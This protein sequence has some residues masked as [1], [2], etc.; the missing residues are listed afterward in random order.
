MS[1]LL[2]MTTEIV[3]AHASATGMKKEDLL[4]EIGQVFVRLAGIAGVDVPAGQVPV[5]Q[6]APAEPEPIK[7]AVPLEAAFGAD[8]VFCMECGQ[9]MKT[10]KRHISSA[11]GMKPG[12]YRR[13]FG[14]PSG[15]PLVAKNYSDQRKAMA[16]DLKLGERLV[17]AR[18][19]KGKK[20]KRK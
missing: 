17:K 3:S 2:A 12:E 4:E 18:A 9:G 10:L 19:A 8:K 6:A 20:A 5:P 7:P 1:K 15:T 14:I 16:K 13:K 11:H